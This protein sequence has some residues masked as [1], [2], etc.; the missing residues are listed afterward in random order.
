MKWFQ[1]SVVYEI[2]PR[3]FKDTNHDGVGD[4]R[5]VIQKLDYFKELGIGALW[6][7]PVYTSPMADFGYDVAD[8]CGVDPIF[9][10]IRELDDLINKAHEK[11][12]KVIMDFVPNHTSDKHP[13][14]EA[15]RSSEDD[16][17][18]SRY[19]WKKGKKDGSP[20]NWLS[21]FGGSGWE[22]DDKTQS[23]YYHSFLKEQPD[24]NWRNPEV[25]EA[26]KNVLRFW[27][28]RGVD[29]FRVDVVY[30]I[31]KD[32]EF[33][34]NPLNPQFVPGTDNPYMEQIHVYDKGLPETLGIVKEFCHVLEEYKDKCLISEIYAPF[35]KLKPY[36]AACDTKIH[37]PFN[38]NLIGLNWS[39]E[40][41][42]SLVEEVESNLREDDMPNYILGNHDKSRVV[43]RVGKPRARLL[44]MLQM[45]LRSTPFIYYGE[46][47]GMENGDI[48]EDEI[49]D[50]FEKHVPGMGLGRDPMRTPMQ[51]TAEQYSGFSEARPWLPVASGYAECNVV[52]ERGDPASFLNLY[53]KLIHTRNTSDALLKGK[54]ETV[55]VDNEEVYAYSRAY[56]KEKFIVLLN[57]S[58][59]EQKI[60]LRGRYVLVCSSFMDKAK[61]GNVDSR[62][63]TLRPN[64]GQLLR[65]EV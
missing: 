40:D 24:L 63:V 30:Y 56:E 19:I 48:H 35:E 25:K 64:E 21:T 28:D 20:N 58:D 7:A 49:R 47:L 1:K 15:S 39:A 53:K 52:S 4:L 42:R 43:S 31:F 46:E 44:A 27:L 61:E 26:M 50:N 11:E 23:Y 55:D 2:Y 16:P 54:Y 59:Q 8:Y 3:S 22:Y 18:R 37:F 29:G 62:R 6:L 32:A 36:Y 41:Y 65:V 57:F 60:L 12:I 14:F 51:W 45:T 9:G 34:D 17:K 33:K 10:T 38:M 5:G 13:W